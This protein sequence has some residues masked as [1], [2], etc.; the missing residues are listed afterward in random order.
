M[1]AMSYLNLQMFWPWY[2]HVRVNTDESIIA[3]KH[4]HRTGYAGNKLVK[5]ITL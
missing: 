4:G 3:V 1:F 2:I 5:E